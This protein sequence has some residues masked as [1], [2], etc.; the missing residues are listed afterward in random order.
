[1]KNFGTIIQV[2]NIHKNNLEHKKK[3]INSIKIQFEA[4]ISLLSS[5][6]Y[7]LYNKNLV[8]TEALKAED[9]VNGTAKEIWR[10]TNCG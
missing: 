6:S 7:L 8:V 5:Y 9:V 2:R 3:F 10:S 4:S 1:M